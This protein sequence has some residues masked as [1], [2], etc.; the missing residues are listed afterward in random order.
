MR[1]AAILAPLLLLVEGVASVGAATPTPSQNHGFVGTRLLDIPAERRNDP[2]AQTYIIDHLMP[3]AVI[4]RHIEVDSTVDAPLLVEVFV[5]AASI[6]GGGF[7][8]GADR[9]RNELTTWMSLD[10][11]SVHPSSKRQGAGR[12]RLPRAPNASSGPGPERCPHQGRAAR[13][14][15]GGQEHRPSRAGHAGRPQAL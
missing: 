14:H 13:G 4:R 9:A 3:G 6:S 2:R 1:L 7:V 12:G 10:H 8:G 5:G 15:R 11:S